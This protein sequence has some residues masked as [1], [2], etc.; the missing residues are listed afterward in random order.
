MGRPAR[1]KS[2][3]RRKE[4]PSGP[5]IEKYRRVRDQLRTERGRRKQ[6]ELCDELDLIWHGLDSKQRKELMRECMQG[7]N[8]ARQ[9]N[10]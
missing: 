7:D 8:L 1:K 9:V 3:Y 2:T 4:Y 10:E 6:R 5:A